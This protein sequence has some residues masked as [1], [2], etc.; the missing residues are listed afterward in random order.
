MRE[1]V[2]TSFS[3]LFS[4]PFFFCSTLLPDPTSCSTWLGDHVHDHTANYLTAACTFSI[5][6]TIR[7]Q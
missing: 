5:I 1:N 2:L 7:A 4:S 6:I 3:F